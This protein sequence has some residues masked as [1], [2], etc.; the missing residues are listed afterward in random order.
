MEPQDAAPFE[1]IE[2]E[3]AGRHEPSRAA[4]DEYTVLEKQGRGCGHIHGF[5]IHHRANGPEVGESQMAE[6]KGP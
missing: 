4:V 1:T 2:G 3:G 6:H 5:R